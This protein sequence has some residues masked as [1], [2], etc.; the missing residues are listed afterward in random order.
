MK[1]ATEVEAL[2]K[3]ITV[4]LKMNN[5]FTKRKTEWFS[6]KVL[7]NQVK[8]KYLKYGIRKYTINFS[9]KLTK[10]AHKKNR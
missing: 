9:K 3:L 1:K 8:W 5:M 7:G 4:S 2:G 6:E 10:N